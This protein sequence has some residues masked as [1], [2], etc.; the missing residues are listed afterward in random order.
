MEVSHQSFLRGY[1]GAA[2]PITDQGL[3]HDIVSQTHI[4]W[5][6]RA[7]QILDLLMT[8]MYERPLAM[9]AFRDYSS[10]HR[11]FNK[12]YKEYNKRVHGPCSTSVIVLLHCL[13]KKGLLSR[14]TRLCLGRV[15]WST[16]TAREWA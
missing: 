7:E 16:R 10:V 2:V 14:D 11:W 3:L 6:L 12:G 13:R 1:L 9:P 15:L 8:I 4:G 5:R